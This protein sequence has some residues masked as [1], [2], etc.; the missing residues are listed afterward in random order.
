MLS[1][2]FS[3]IARLAWL[4]A[5]RWAGKRAALAAAILVALL[6]AACSGATT[7]PP[8]PTSPASAP[9]PAGQ[10]TARPTA[11]PSLAPTR[12]PTRGA[13]AANI[14]C[15]KT[16]TG[17]QTPR[18]PTITLDTLLRCRPEVQQ[19]ISNI[20]RGRFQYDQDDQTF[21][22]RERYLPGAPTGT[23][24]EYTVISPGESTRGAHRIITSGPPDR[25]SKAFIDMY[26]TDDHYGSYWLVTSGK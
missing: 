23:Y 16:L 8:N 13:G 22:N 2:L 5:P 17:G 7:P 20:N 14:D 18:I 6:V 15:T 12:Q 11:R 19:T 24:R 26:Y 1:L 9:T 4:R 10:P 25:Q 21:S 3:M